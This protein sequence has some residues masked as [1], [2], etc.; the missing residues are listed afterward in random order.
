MINYPSLN[1]RKPYVTDEE[2]KQRDRDNAKLYYQNNKDD[3][4]FIKK[5]NR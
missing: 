5:R 1:S 4:E 2:R 3:E